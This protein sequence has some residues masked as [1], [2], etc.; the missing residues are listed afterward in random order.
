MRVILNLED[1]MR[2]RGHISPRQQEKLDGLN[3][4]YNER[5]GVSYDAV[6]EKLNSQNK[7]IKGFT[8]TKK[9]LKFVGNNKKYYIWTAIVLFFAVFVNI[10]M[11]FLQNLTTIAKNENN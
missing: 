4:R 1:I 8:N 3:A 9:I 7:R 5:Y 10:F 11:A 2:E 6:Q